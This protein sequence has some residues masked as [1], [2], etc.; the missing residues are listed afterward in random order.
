[1]PDAMKKFAN[2]RLNRRSFFRTRP[3]PARR[4]K[5]LRR[6]FVTAQASESLVLLPMGQVSW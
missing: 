5:I 1:M 3:F 2:L 4:L 6:F